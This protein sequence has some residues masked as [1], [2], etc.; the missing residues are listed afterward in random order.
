M[1]K[2]DVA[3]GETPKTETQ[4]VPVPV[5]PEVEKPEEKEEEFD[6]DRAMA[7][8]AKLREAEKAGK[9]AEKE[10]AALKEAEAKRQEAEL[11]ELQKAQKRAKEL[12]DALATKE[13]EAL[14]RKVADA[15]GL[16]A[17][18]ASRLVGKDEEE[19]TADATK[20]LET[21]PKAEPTKKGGPTIQPTNPAS[22]NKT[23]TLAEKKQRLHVTRGSEVWDQSYAEAQGGGAF[24]V[25][26]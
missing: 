2:E 17:I 11:T 20:L 5:V 10:L 23:E 21:L 15:T 4:V 9:K 22:A 8:I 26:K 24:V 12:E 7:T 6:K 1:S 16:P 14:Q 18:L 3:K 19:M 25:E 13:H